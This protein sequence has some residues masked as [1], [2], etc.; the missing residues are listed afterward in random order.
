[1]LDKLAIVPVKVLFTGEITSEG[2]LK[3]LLGPSHFITPDAPARLRD[4]AAN[5]RLD[6]ERVIS[7]T[8]ISGRMEGLYVKI[9]EQ[10]VVKE[11]LKFV[12]RDFITRVTDGGEHW[13]NRPLIPNALRDGVNL[14][15]E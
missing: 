10:G 4:V 15:T 11:R 7:Q 9:E 2:S 6:P 14:F 1:L 8:D 13:M 12:R 5:M 3:N